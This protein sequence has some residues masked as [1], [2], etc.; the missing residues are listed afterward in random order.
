MA[1]VLCLSLENHQELWED[2]RVHEDVHIIVSSQ[3]AQAVWNIAPADHDGLAV[4]MKKSQ[5]L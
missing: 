5:M 2:G 3:I 4:V 1:K